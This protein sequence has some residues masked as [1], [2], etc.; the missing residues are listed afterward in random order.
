MIQS[1]KLRRFFRQLAIAYSPL[2]RV[3]M[4]V[5]VAVS[6]FSI[7][8]CIAAAQTRTALSNTTALY[9]RLIRLAHNSDASKNGLI[10]ASVTGFR[11]GSGEEDIYSSADGRTFAQI[12]AIVDSDF[13]SGLCCGTL[14]E[15]PAQVGALA[16]GTL[17]WSGSVGQQSTTQPM[18]LKIYKSTDGGATWSYL[19]NCAT[20][21]SPKSVGGGLWEPQFE[22]ADDGAL[23]CFYSDETQSGHSQL[24]HQ[25]RS[26]DGINWKDSTFTV[27]STI[28]NDRPGMPVVTKLPSGTYFMSYELCGPAAC[29]VFSRT[30]SDGWNWGDPANMGRKVQ[31]VSGQWLEHAPTNVWSPSATSTNGTILLIGQMLYDASGA[32]SSGNGITILTNH[33]ADGS[34]TWNTMPAPVQV[35]TAYNNYC[36]NYSSSLLPST[37]GTTLLE[38]ASDYVGSTCTTFFNTGPVLAGTVAPTVTVSPAVTRVSGFP[39]QVAV[40]V[41]GK[42]AAPAPTGQVTLTAGSYSATAILTNGTVSFSI[43]GPLPGGQQILSVAYAGDS[44]YTAAT[45][46]ATVTVVATPAVT[47]TP[48]AST[49][50][51]AQA[52]NVAIAVTH[53]GTV[54]P[55][56]GSVS[57]TSGSFASGAVDL[58]GGAAS[59]TIPGNSL[60]LGTDQLTATYTGDSNY[61][62]QT[63]T[64]SIDVA[65]APGFTMS[66]TPVSV[67]AGAVT[68]NTST[69]TLRSFAGFSGSVSLSASILQFNGASTMPQN[70]P[71]FTFAPAGLVTLAAD[72]ALTATLQVSTTGASIA[73]N[74][75][76]PLRSP[77]TQG[78]EAIA[79]G[80][81]LLFGFRRRG[82]QRS[83]VV[84][85]LCLF[86][87]VLG[88]SGC[89]SSTAGHVASATTAGSYLVKVTG[90]AG[91]A[92]AQTTIT[93]NVQ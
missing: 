9:P 33:S 65:A 53:E 25:V 80:S 56:T 12:G 66:A 62:A 26:Y 60:S 59:V 13:A 93:V 6:V 86:A 52:L 11:N 40:S 21:T 78:S 20:A 18:Q 43:P 48:A 29:T 19:S 1:L 90:T 68:G 73:A 47:I 79:F 38:F 82:K 23:V 58:T 64:A 32:V 39:L 10:V 84:T 55:P 28:S 5:I 50:A 63:G 7:S 74:R 88:C 36:P 72:S 91:A 15:L 54:T 89:N 34:G 61:A 92:N 22:I 35:P 16:P 57:L 8:A 37:D 44:N 3:N 4:G 51:A 14:F 67:P 46:S 85:S 87:A 71:V 83:A 75:P 24:I 77:A 69:V 76:V 30:S 70:P 81:L 2:C 42:S 45:G 27:A 41:T 49:I 31:T 17:L